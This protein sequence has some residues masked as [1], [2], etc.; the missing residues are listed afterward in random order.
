M[1]EGF[2]PTVRVDAHRENTLEGQDGMLGGPY[3]TKTEAVAAGCAEA[4]RRR[5]KHV[6]H[7]EDGAIGER[8]SY[9]GDPA[10]RP[11]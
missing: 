9:G 5:T 1:A 2:V 8:N 4:Q 10:H 6:I 7:N 11:G 3:E